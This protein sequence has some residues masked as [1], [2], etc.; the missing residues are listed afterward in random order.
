MGDLKPMPLRNPSS[1]VLRPLLTGER[2][3]LPAPLAH[4]TLS[5]GLLFISTLTSSS[6]GQNPTHAFL[7]L[8]S[9]CSPS[10]LLSLPPKWYQCLPTGPAVTLHL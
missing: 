10:G 3:A 4:H 5:L 8:P 9:C 1:S 2:A 7:S 6:L